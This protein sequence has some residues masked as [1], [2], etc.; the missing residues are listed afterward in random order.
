MTARSAA[1]PLGHASIVAGRRWQRSVG[2]PGARSRCCAC[3]SFPV[4][5]QRIFAGSGRAH[6]IVAPC[7]HRGARACGDVRD[8]R[9]AAG[10]AAAVRVPRC[11]GCLRTVVEEARRAT[12]PHKSLQTARS[13]QTTRISRALM[14][15]LERRHAARRRRNRRADIRQAISLDQPMAFPS[16]I[17]GGAEAW[18]WQI[19]WRR[20]CAVILDPPR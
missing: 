14:P 15:V 6:L 8:G 12:W 5:V 4:R 7:R 17:V 19:C 10:K 18:R 13:F 2:A 16:L 3:V 9:G 11:G 20:P 1:G